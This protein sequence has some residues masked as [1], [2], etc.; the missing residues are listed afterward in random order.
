MSAIMEQTSIEQVTSSTV[1]SVALPTV[2]YDLTGPLINAMVIVSPSD[3]PG[4]YIHQ[5][6]PICVPGPTSSAWTVKWTLVPAE[7]LSAIFAADAVSTP[8]PQ[9]PGQSRPVPGD[10]LFSGSTTLQPP[11]QCQAQITNNVTAIDFF[12]Y[13]LNMGVTGANGVSLTPSPNVGFNTVDP[14]IALVK[15]PIG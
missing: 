1:G 11:S 9:D 7:G 12:N 14:T 5:I 10:V 8:D 2:T 13:K 4:E 3:T 6:P 15:E